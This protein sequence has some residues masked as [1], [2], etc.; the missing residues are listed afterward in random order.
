MKL[1]KL[2]KRKSI[3]YMHTILYIRKDKNK[4]KKLKSVTSQLE[5][6]GGKYR[7]N[8]SVKQPVRQ[9]VTV[10]NKAKRSNST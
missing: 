2:K 7:Y 9:Y 3:N 1:S 10:S 6:I 5:V 4:N 8:R